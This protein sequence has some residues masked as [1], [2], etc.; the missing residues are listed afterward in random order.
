MSKQYRLSPSI[1]L[2]HVAML[3]SQPVQIVRH[4]PPAHSRPE[5]ELLLV[6][7]Q[8]NQLRARPALLGFAFEE[9]VS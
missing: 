9:I 3:G 4:S 1:H 5:G 2:P 8:G 7:A 6:T